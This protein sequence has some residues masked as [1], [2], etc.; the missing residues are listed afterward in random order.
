MS[1][2][3]EPQQRA[4]MR[5]RIISHHITKVAIYIAKEVSQ[6]I[7]NY[8][9]VAQAFGEW[10]KNDEMDKDSFMYAHMYGFHNTRQ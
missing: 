6:I 8:Q 7:Q 3:W 10:R 1:D 9:E 2:K 4:E 5:T